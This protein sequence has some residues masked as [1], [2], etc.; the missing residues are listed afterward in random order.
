MNINL[1]CPIFVLESELNPNIR[2]SDVKKLKLLVFHDRNLV[3]IKVE[4]K[5]TL[6]TILRD[7]ITSIIGSD[8]FH[9]EQ[10][11][12]LGEEK[13]Y[14]DNYIDIIYLAVTNIENLKKLDSDYQL[15]DFNI[16][17]NNIVF[18]HENY[19]FKTKEHVINNNVE[20]YHEIDTDNIKLE[21]ELLEIIIAYKQ[22]RTKLDHSD[23]L[24]KFM[25]KYFTLED[26]RIVYE[27][28]KEVSVDKS[29]FRKK[30]VKYCVE[31]KADISKKGYRPS[32]VYTFKVLKGDVWL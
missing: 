24:F 2:K 3:N 4:N 7:K 8:K 29:N 13:Y 32:K 20:Y 16:R 21:K 19:K 17:N 5:N 31:T 22:L 23:I 10:V 15:V 6:K 12:A 14:F 18:D 9:L 30:I 1:V 25:P 26:V 11:Y 27:L 28:I